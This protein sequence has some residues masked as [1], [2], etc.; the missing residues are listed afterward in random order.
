[1][2]DADGSADVLDCLN[3]PVFCNIMELLKLCH[4]FCSMS[5]VAS[6]RESEDYYL[7]GYS[8]R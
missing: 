7:R 4:S 1:M 3:N 5:D 2:P 6:D 8:D